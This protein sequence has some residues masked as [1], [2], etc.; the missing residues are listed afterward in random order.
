MNEIIEANSSALTVAG[1][2]IAG[3]GATFRVIG[4]TAKAAS[5]LADL[6]LAQMRLSVTKL[7][8][9]ALCVELKTLALKRRCAEMT[10]FIGLMAH[11]QTSGGQK[12]MDC[13]LFC[14]SVLELP[15]WEKFIGVVLAEYNRDLEASIHFMTSHVNAW[16]EGEMKGLSQ[17][18]LMSNSRR[19]LLN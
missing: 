3:I 13:A 9:S 5:R 12:G 2:S 1:K 16:R 19:G 10:K 14:A 18:L 17:Q 11:F 6:P 15:D 8:Y 4:A 7:H